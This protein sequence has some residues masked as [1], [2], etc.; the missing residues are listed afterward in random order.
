MCMG[1]LNGELPWKW[2]HVN[3]YINTV[4]DGA[5]KIVS[6]FSVLWLCLE[7]E[8]VRF[9]SRNLCFTHVLLL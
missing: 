6:K 5:E 1:Q 2:S 3:K 7:I 4:A 8:V 9:R